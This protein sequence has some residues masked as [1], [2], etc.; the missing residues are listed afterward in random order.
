MTGVAQANSGKPV[1]ILVRG[2]NWLGDAVMT[3]P[4][5][6]RL[7]EARPDDSI[8]LLTDEKI[9]DLFAGHPAVD[10]VICFSKRDSLLQ[11][12]RK[13]RQ[14]RFDLALVF[15]NSLRSA[16]ETF[17]ARIPTRIGYTRNGRGLF[18]TQRVQPRAD[19]H[20]MRKRSDAEIRR[21]ITGPKTAGE[22]PSIS[23]NVHHIHNYLH[24]TQALGARPEALP[25][26]IAVQHAEIEAVLTKFDLEQYRRRKIPFFGLN[27]G[28]EYG[29]AKRWPVERFI[30]A[31]VDIQK[32]TG[33]CWLIFGGP[34]DQD[35]AA[36][37]ER[38]IAQTRA[39]LATKP[40]PGE[41]VNLAG[42][43]SLRDLC[44]ALSLCSV[45]LTNDTGPMH[46]AAAVG[47][48]VVVPFGSTS[49]ELTAPG[50]PG[51]PRHSILRAGAPCSPCFR[52]T[53]PID[54][55]CLKG[56]QAEEVAKAVVAAAAPVNNAR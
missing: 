30:A 40:A 52:R 10:R 56:I 55:R 18:L 48:P 26:R 4:A 5:L 22:A 1:K 54:L 36:T 17:L 47:V 21:L 34:G 31:A 19:E 12:A 50:L 3:T 27:P 24:L 7:R 45:V 37:M 16:L 46:L 15:P 39:E 42:K 29:S 20:A 2:V 33:C 49:P 11:V 38:G 28:A 41:V 53:C 25:P 8:T 43:T 6:Q 44:A 51:D 32:L 35:L 23:A 9:G 13:L 14:E